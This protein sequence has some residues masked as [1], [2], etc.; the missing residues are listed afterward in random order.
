MN[1]GVDFFK[2]TRHA[3]HDR[4]AND[5]HVVLQKTDVAVK[6]NKAAHAKRIVVRRGAL[7]GM[8]QRQK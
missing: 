5:A 4:W 2:N 7:K 3:H 8:R 1:L 6:S